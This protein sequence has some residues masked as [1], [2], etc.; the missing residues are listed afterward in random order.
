M[1]P[2]HRHQSAAPDRKWRHRKRRKQSWKQPMARVT[3]VFA[4]SYVHH[5]D[6]KV[7]VWLHPAPAPGSRL[8]NLWKGW[9]SAQR[10]TLWQINTQFDAKMFPWHLSSI[11]MRKLNLRSCFWRPLSTGLTKVDVSE[12]KSGDDTFIYSYSP[13]KTIGCH[14]G[15]LHADFLLLRCHSELLPSS[16]HRYWTS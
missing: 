12:Q 1:S 13:T 3:L 2:S 7:W 4:W 6:G 16:T 15:S 9:P 10:W 14:K 5:G 8:S 11:K